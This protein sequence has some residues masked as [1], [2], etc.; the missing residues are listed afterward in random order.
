MDG[1]P[2]LDLIRLDEFAPDI[3]KQLFHE[4]SLEEQQNCPTSIYH[5]GLDH[6]DNIFRGF[7]YRSVNDFVSEPLPY[8]LHTKPGY[9]GS[10]A[11][12]QDDLITMMCRQRS[13]QDKLPLEERCH[14]GGEIIVWMMERVVRENARP[15]VSTTILPVYQWADFYEMYAE[16][17]MQFDEQRIFGSIF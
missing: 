17:A 14:I 6:D 7:A 12:P 1:I 13:E 3:L 11:D 4:R 9:D 16:C 10:S 5:L 2:A 8:G 15:T